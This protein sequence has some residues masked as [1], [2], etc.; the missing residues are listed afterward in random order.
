MVCANVEINSGSMGMNDWKWESIALEQSHRRMIKSL[1]VWV[2][3]PSQEE[4]PR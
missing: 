1:P 4:G 3:N 2:K